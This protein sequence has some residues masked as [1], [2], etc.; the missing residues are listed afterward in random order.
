LSKQDIR[1]GK[2]AIWLGYRRNVYVPEPRG[3]IADITEETLAISQATDG[4]AGKESS[5]K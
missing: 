4:A 5:A 3:A 1:I 2:E